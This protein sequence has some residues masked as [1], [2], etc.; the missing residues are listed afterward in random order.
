MQ[1]DT[2]LDLISQWGYPALF[3]SLWLGIVGMPIPDEAIVM[4]GGA[5]TAQGW[6]HPLPAF[7]LTYLGVVSGLSLGYVLGR[8]LGAAAIGRMRKK[9]KLAKYLER[10]EALIA[11]YGQAALVISYFLPVVRHVMPYVVGLNRMPFYRYALF[12]YTTGLLWTGIFFAI[13]QAA[14]VHLDVWIKSVS[15]YG[16]QAAWLIFVLSAVVVI[17]KYVPGRIMSKGDAS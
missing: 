5:V 17:V 16:A 6:L 4:T 2:L 8:F 11:K 12:S 7:A 1:I 15:A 9:P 3:F 10:S 14:G 13:G